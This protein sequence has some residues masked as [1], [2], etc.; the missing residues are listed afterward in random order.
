MNFGIS[1]YPGL[2]TPI[3]A[4]TAL[5]H[6]AAVCGMTLLFT[7]LHIPETDPKTFVEEER[8]MLAAAHRAGL[9]VIAD[10]S[11]T[12]L[13][14]LAKAPFDAPALSVLGFHALRLDDG[15]SPADIARLSHSEGN[16]RLLLN[17]S[18]IGENELAALQAAGADFTRLETLHNFYPRPGTG[19][20][21]AFFRQQNEMLR[22]RDLSI[23]AFLPAVKG[24]RAPLHEGLPTLEL[25]RTMPPDLAARHLA[26]LGVDSI[27]I[28]DDKP[29][30]EEM[31]NLT[32]ISPDTVALHAHLLV[33]TP[34]LKAFL[35]QPFT[36]RPDSARDALRAM[37]GRT[38]F[39]DMPLPPENTA[40]RQF[41]AV[42]IDN[43]DYPRYAGELQI[44]KRPQN[45]DPRTNV[46][47]QV[48]PEEHFLIPLIRPG[49]K[50]VFLFT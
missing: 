35:S 41:G 9:K 11:P 24:R 8:A 13:S 2:G 20:S 37:E 27:F 12:A 26:A 23:G 25:H 14:R 50:F 32:A 3:K 33:K 7:S 29:S 43:H 19:L 1:I 6:R 10:V 30:E 17:A 16:L 44:I 5:I 22:R 36:A 39:H 42:T 15:F 4:Q 48:R 49:Q 31:S 21:L 38:R 34:S 28:G 18:T 47:A 40:P 46:V 45:A